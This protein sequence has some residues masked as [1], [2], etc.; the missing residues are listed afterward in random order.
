MPAVLRSTAVRAF[1]LY[2]SVIHASLI[3]D[4]VPACT[5]V[6]ACSRVAEGML[7][8]NLETETEAVAL[9]LLQ[10]AINSTTHDNAS[11][12]VGHRSGG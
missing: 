11:S 2:I 8:T 12:E 9:Q 1:W 5:D 6:Q 3:A 10:L 7:E 4:G